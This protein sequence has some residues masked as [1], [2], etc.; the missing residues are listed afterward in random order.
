MFIIF[1][2]QFFQKEYTTNQIFKIAAV[3]VGTP[4]KLSI[5]LFAQNTSYVIY[6][7]NTFKI[8]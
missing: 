6:M 8:L 7:I 5:F 1:R 3:Y 2:K 4:H